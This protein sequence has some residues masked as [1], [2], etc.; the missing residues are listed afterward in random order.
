MD[1]QDATATVTLG[2]GETTW[3]VLE[4]AIRKPPDP[5][6][7][8]RLVDEAFHDTVDYWRAWMG[9]S[10]Y[11]G[12]WRE[13]VH[14]SALVLKLLVSNRHGSLV[15]ADVR[16]ARGAGWRAQLGLPVHLDPGRLVHALRTHPVGLHGRGGRV[17]GLDRGPLP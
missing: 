7:A 9:R 5:V 1:D 13:T 4:S 10:C 17:H 11:T 8:S 2:P 14:R 3:F 15:R 16:P 6:E 12:R